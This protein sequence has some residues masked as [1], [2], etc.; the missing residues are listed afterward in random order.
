MNLTETFGHA[1]VG[2]GTLGF[3]GE[4][5][6]IHKYLPLLDFTDATFVGKTTTFPPNDGNMPLN[7]RFEPITF[8]PDCVVMDIWRGI[9]L[10]SVGLSGPG[11]KRLLAT[12][13]WQNRTKPFFLSFMPVAK[14]E[15]GQLIET[16]QFVSIL[17][18]ELPT[19]RTSVA[20][21]FNLSCPNVGAD[22]AAILKKA[23]M[24]LDILATLGIPIVVKLNLLVKP[25]AAIEIAQHPACAGIVISNT[26]PFGELAERVKWER[27][28]P[29]GSPLAKRGY[30]GG[31][32]SGAPL[33]A[34]VYYWLKHFR[35]LDKETYVNAGG[36]ILHDWQVTQLWDIGAS[37]ISFASVAVLRPWR[38]AGIIQE[39]RARFRVS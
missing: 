39:A 26:L 37:S 3:F 8:F 27:Y 9:G 16:Q 1:W 13:R 34:E 38:V 6:R 18:K 10:N 17:K 31:G 7:E 19:F 11:F 25:E 35:K 24:L 4:G 33:F 5:Y 29:H 2:S 14:D 30:G 21:Q 36:G 22:L 32:L 23:A 28:F 12:G 20:L 15:E